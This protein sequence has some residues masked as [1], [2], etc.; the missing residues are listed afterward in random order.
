MKIAYSLPG[1]ADSRDEIGVPVRSGR[2]GRADGG[3]PGGLPTPG[4]LKHI[5]NGSAADVIRAAADAQRAADL[6]ALGKGDTSSLLG[7]AAGRASGL[8]L[9]RFVSSP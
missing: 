9:A 3:E 1:G 2:C 7:C 4:W 6:L 5:R 8:A